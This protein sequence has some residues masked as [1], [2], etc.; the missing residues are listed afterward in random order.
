[1]SLEGLNDWISDCL[2]EQINPGFDLHLGVVISPPGYGMRVQFHP[3]HSV[4]NQWQKYPHLL[5]LEST[6][7][8]IDCSCEPNVH[9]F[10]YVFAVEFAALF[11]LLLL[12]VVAIFQSFSLGQLKVVLELNGEGS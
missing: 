11:L 3:Q 8:S 12:D 5:I 6:E 10:L 9:V 4:H 7:L 1:M 2:F